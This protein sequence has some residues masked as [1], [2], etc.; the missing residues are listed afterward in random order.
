MSPR[1]SIRRDLVR[2]RFIGD[3][4]HVFREM[5]LCPSCGSDV[6]AEQNFCRAC[7]EDLSRV[8]PQSAPKPGAG[9]C[10]NCNVSVT[11]EQ[12]FCRD[13]GQDL[14]VWRGRQTQG[15]V[16]GAT[17][18]PHIPDEHGAYVTDERVRKIQDVLDDDER[19]HYLTRGSTVDVEGSSA[20]QSLSGDDRSRKSGT[21]GYVRAAITDR[22]VVVKVPQWLGD[23]E[24]TI[25]YRNVTS[26]D[27]DTGYVVKRLSLQT[28]G[29]TYHIEVHE[30]DK[31][32]VREAV[33]FVRER[34]AEAQTDTVVVEGAGEP[35][36]TEQL[37]NVKQLH[38]DGVLTDEEFERKKQELLD[39]I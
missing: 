24:R 29:Q 7:G 9:L 26:V 19:V 10:P 32:E 8:G 11:P 31:A 5:P 4:S 23:D 37:K 2:Q 27:L 30:P 17:D 35:D 13:C 16:Q 1:D 34:I 39:K 21:R 6:S 33:K 14:T 18:S 15:T 25:P 38:E 28:P 22:R 12:N 36:P 3:R 20:G